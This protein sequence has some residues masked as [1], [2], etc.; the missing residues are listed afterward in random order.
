METWSWVEEGD[1]RA[2]SCS[3]KSR[4]VLAP[5]G[6][7]MGSFPSSSC[8]HIFLGFVQPNFRCL[9]Q[10]ISLL[11]LLHSPDSSLSER[12]EVFKR[13]MDVALRDIV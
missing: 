12:L 5:G 11:R 4:R 13:R 8:L 1:G 7:T 10:R 3:G 2:G 6:L 9:K